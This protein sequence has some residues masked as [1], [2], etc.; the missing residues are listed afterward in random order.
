MGS[1]QRRGGSKREVM[2][3]R[4]EDKREERKR[5]RESQNRERRLPSQEALESVPSHRNRNFTVRARC[6][7]H[8]RCY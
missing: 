8:T 3:G 5:E 6:G 7:F 2:G 4:G 1:A